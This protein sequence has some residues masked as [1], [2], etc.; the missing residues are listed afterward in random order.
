MLRI[1]SGGQTGVDRA[2]LDVAAELGLERGGWCPRGRRAEDGVIPARYSLRETPSAAYSQRTRWNVRDAQ[3]T[4]ILV[5]GEPSGGTART[6]EFAAR[7]GRPCLVVEVTAA[8]AVA[9]ARAFIAESGAAILNVAG[10]RESNARGIGDEA[11]RLLRRAL[12]PWAPRR[13]SSS[14]IAGT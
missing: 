13:Q 5:R 2:A 8:D 3:A 7:L 14:G 10:P 4:L 11:S 1:V 9:R 6:V 12:A